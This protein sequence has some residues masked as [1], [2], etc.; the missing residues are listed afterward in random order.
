MTSLYTLTD[1]LYLQV[2]SLLHLNVASCLQLTNKGVELLAS[3]TKLQHLN[4][5]FCKKVTDDGIF[6]LS[7]LTGLTSLSMQGC[8]SW[9]KQVGCFKMAALQHMPNLA[10][11]NLA[12]GHFQPL[13][14]LPLG[15]LTSLTQLNVRS[16]KRLSESDLQAIGSLQRLQHLNLEA[17]QVVTSANMKHVQ[18]LQQLTFL[19]MARNHSLSDAAIAQLMSMTR[20]QH[21]ELTDCPGITE[22]ALDKLY[23]A[24]PK[25]RT[26]QSNGIDKEVVQ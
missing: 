12:E 7:Q 2:P 13:A 24:L 8:G 14:L 22:P 25:L 3:M 6:T 16:C 11:L 10:E 4:L 15:R 9:C 19:T 21:L 18:P 20:L 1:T 26:L 5:D 23:V 17:C